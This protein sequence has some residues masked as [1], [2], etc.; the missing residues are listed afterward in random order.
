LDVTV[1]GSLRLVVV[2]ATVDGVLT[3]TVVV[4]VTCSGTQVDPSVPQTYTNT[5]D[6]N[7][8]R[9]RMP[10][11]LFESTQRSNVRK[12]QPIYSCTVDRCLVMPSS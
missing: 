7:P 2:V 3:V 6:I 10:T 12:T 5:N 11:N 1:V 4:D 9:R 8:H